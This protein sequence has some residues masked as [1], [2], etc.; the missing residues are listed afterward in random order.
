MLAYVFEKTAMGKKVLIV[1]RSRQVA[2]LSGI[3]VKKIRFMCFVVSGVISGIAGILYTGILGGG[4]PTAGLAYMLPAFAAVYLGSTCLKPGR[5]NAFGT[6][7]AV[8]FL[9]TGTNGLSLQGVQSYIQNIFYGGALIIAV[10]F[11][12]AVK[13]LKEGREIKAAKLAREKEEKDL[14]EKITAKKAQ[15]VAS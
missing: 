15:P 1:G 10:V 6:I 9:T 4:N 7:I 12:V 2:Q 13:S 5:F 8:Y 11:S 3:N 14:M